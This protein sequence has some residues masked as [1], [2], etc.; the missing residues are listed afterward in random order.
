MVTPRSLIHEMNNSGPLID[1][2]ELSAIHNLN[3]TEPGS[4]A[5][6]TTALY[7][8]WAI[9]TG[10]QS[11]LFDGT[12]SILAH[13]ITKKEE[14]LKTYPRPLY[15]FSGEQQDDDLKDSPQCITVF[16]QNNTIYRYVC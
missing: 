15:I 11:R 2:S 3:T 14:F 12:T 9:Q 16:H 7:S 6:S 8:P 1:E 4:Y 5:M 13:D 10:P